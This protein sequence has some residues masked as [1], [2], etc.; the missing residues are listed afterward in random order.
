MAFELEKRIRVLK[1]D[2]TGSHLNKT[3]GRGGIRTHGELPP[4][5]NT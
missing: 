1:N 2:G 4:S 5:K 3:G